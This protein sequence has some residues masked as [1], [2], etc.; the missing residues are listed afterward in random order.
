MKHDFCKVL[1]VFLAAALLTPPVPA[2]AAPQQAQGQD[3]QSN[4]PPAPQSTKPP[5]AV[6]VPV[7]TEPQPAN[8]PKAPQIMRTS[9]DIVRIDVEVTDRSGKP[10]KG[11]AADKF[12]ITDNGKAQKISIFSYSDIE[13][14]ETASADDS[15]PIVIAVDSPTP[16]PQETLDSQ[17]RDRRMIVLFFDLSSMQSDDLLRAH[18]AALKFVQKQMSKADLVSVVVYSS[19]LTVWADFTNDRA[20]LEKAVARLTADASSQ[21]ADNSYAAAQE[22]EY[23]V[24]EYTGAAYTAD[25]T[26]FNVFNTGEKLA[27]IEG[28]ANVLGAIPGR[29]AM[30]EFTGGITQTGEENRTDLRAATD[31]ANLADVSIYSIDARGLFA[32]PPG[33]DATVNASTG[34]S[35]FTGAS[36]FHQTDQRQDSRDTLATLS[37]DTGGRAF[38]D[39]GDLSDAF[40][41]IEA[42]NTGYYLLGYYLNTDIKRDGRWR[43]IHV[44]V[45]APGVHVRFRNGYFAPRDFQHLE[46]EGRQQQLADAMSSDNPI[47]ELPIAVETSMFRVNDQQFYVPIDAKLSSSALDWAEKH[48]RHEAAFDFAAEVRA[49]PANRVV[50]DLQDTITVQLDTARFQQVKQSNL[51]Y[52]GG[53]ILAPGSYRMKFVARENESGKIG[54]FEED[55]VIPQA[56]PGRIALSSVLLSSQLVPVEKSAEVQTKGQGIR[57]NLASSPLEMGGEKIIPSV[58][59]FFNQQQTLYVF[60]QAYYPE[61]AEKSGDFDPATLRAGLIFFRNGIQVNSTPLLA[62]AEVNAKSHTASYRISLPV[63]K[64]PAGR[65]TVQAVV[66]AAGTQHSAFGRAY[67]AVEQAPTAPNS[68]IPAPAPVAAPEP[69]KPPSK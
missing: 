44:K 17:I 63:A 35:M 26:E 8:T 9:S 51:L 10:V 21:L 52:Q 56:Q 34:N 30:I 59:R 23:D 13:S 64:L 36:V 14:V 54:T 40:P 49:V 6:P 25:E 18:D 7:K 39:L 66:V 38:Y 32:A 61:K 4:A 43:A 11:L 31:A 60:F 29:K 19:K 3:Q 53:V 68:P 55:L 33:G 65:Y 24:Q 41:K 12:T 1:A 46:K 22:G 27:A 16:V 57:A 58:T 62:P 37:S 5:V 69:Q 42:D 15:K 28:L 50:A 2:A 47:V 20:K 67:L 48:D 45:N